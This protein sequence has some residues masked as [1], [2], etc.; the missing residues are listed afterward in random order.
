MTALAKDKN[1]NSKETTRSIAVQVAAGA[2][3]FAGAMVAA[4]S[5][6]FAIPAS[7]T[8]GIVVM[9]ISE[10]AADNTSGADGALEIRIRKGTFEL[11]TA[12]TVVDQADVGRRVFVSDD[13]TVEKAAGVVNNIPAGT[14]DSFDTDTGN[15]WVRLPEEE[16][17]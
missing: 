16:L 12:G 10:E 7:D 1:V 3:I 17:T 5:T 4:N 9:G 15:P 6:G 13:A 14:L 11:L 2:N 8:S